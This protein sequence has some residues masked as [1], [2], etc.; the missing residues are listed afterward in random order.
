MGEVNSRFASHAIKQGQIIK[1]RKL[2]LFKPENI[3]VLRFLLYLEPLQC[4]GTEA[5][6]DPD[7]IGSLDPD[8][9]RQKLPR[10]KL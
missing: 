6:L 8:S 7:S 5:G 10:K 9:G 3:Y 2:S 1:S 4:F